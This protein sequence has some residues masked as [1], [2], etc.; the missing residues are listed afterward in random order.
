[1]DLNSLFVFSSEEGDMYFKKPEQLQ[2]LFNS[3]EEKNLFIIKNSNDIEQS[4]E[5]LKH[6]FEMKK[7]LLAEKERQLRKNKQDLERGIKV[8]Y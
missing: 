7:D 5:D 8:I 6:V 2:D 4:L 1:M 3:L